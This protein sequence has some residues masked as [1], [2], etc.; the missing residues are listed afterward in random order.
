L[1]KLLPDI[2]HNITIALSP[3]KVKS[4]KWAQVRVGIFTLLKEILLVQEGTNANVASPGLTSSNS[5][6]NIVISRSERLDEKI[7]KH[8]DF[9]ALMAAVVSALADKSSNLRIETLVFL[10]LLLQNL[11]AESFHP[12]IESLAPAI[13]D[14]VANNYYKIVAEALRVCAALVTV[15]RPLVSFSLQRSLIHAGFTKLVIFK[16]NR[17]M[18]SSLITDLTLVLFMNLFFPS[19]KPRIL[20]R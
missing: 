20:I 15:L 12:F 18:K 10:R 16:L 4:P 3:D 6:N 9:P 1:R 7:G 17:I 19:C 14:S 8:P 5:N 2:I 11:S 13:F